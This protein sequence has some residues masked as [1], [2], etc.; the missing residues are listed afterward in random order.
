ML[1]R[2]VYTAALAALVPA[3]ATAGGEFKVKGL[4]LPGGAV[5]VAEDRYRLSETW[6]GAMKFLK[7]QY[8]QEKFPRRSVV[9]QPGIKAIH[10]D[11][12]DAAGEW[13]GFNLYEYQ[14]EVRLYIL[15]RT[16]R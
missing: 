7:A 4:T 2:L 16:K 1:R 10:I 5:R 8:R 6:T 11:N 14:G 9:N 13:E 15:T 12:P 3:V